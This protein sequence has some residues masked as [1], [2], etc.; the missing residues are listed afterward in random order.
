MAYVSKN[1]KLLRLMVGK[2]IEE[3]EELSK[4]FKSSAF[5]AYTKE[6]RN[7]TISNE[8]RFNKVCENLFLAHVY[9]RLY[10]VDR[11]VYVFVYTHSRSEM[12]AYFNK[13]NLV[14][15]EMFINNKSFL[16]SAE[17]KESTVVTTRSKIRALFA[18]AKEFK[19][20][21]KKAISRFQS[22]L[23]SIVITKSS[24]PVQE[25]PTLDSFESET[26]PVLKSIK[27]SIE[28]EPKDLDAA[29]KALNSIGINFI[30]YNKF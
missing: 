25:T 11:E 2:T 18:Y 16:R 3:I 19:Y 24:E 27:Y 6:R 29:C 5:S 9:T 20:A 23:E 13:N 22:E 28:I 8:D 4:N 7:S 14:A 30:L 26:V 17:Y 10:T 21:N 12:I 15:A 1:E